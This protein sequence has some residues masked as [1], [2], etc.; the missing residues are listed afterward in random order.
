[1][2]PYS[3]KLKL[4]DGYSQGVKREGKKTTVKF[5]PNSTDA[6]SHTNIQDPCTMPLHAVITSRPAHPKR[7]KLVN[8]TEQ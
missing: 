2:F 7:I 8:V 6:C 4:E 5:M 3:V 1:M